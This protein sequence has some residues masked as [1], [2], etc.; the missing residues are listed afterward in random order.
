MQKNRI[1]SASNS[2][3]SRH[4]R[5][6][7]PSSVSMSDKNSSHFGDSSSAQDDNSSLS[8]ESSSSGSSNK[9]EETERYRIVRS[10]QQCT[11]L[12]ACCTQHTIVT[13]LSSRR[14]E[15]QDGIW[16]VQNDPPG[17]IMLLIGVSPQMFLLF[18]C[19]CVLTSSYYVLLWQIQPCRFSFVALQW[20][21]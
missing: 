5:H 20:S 6:N 16:L 8:R 12:Y 10:V 18:S 3:L 13:F 14:H 4:H 17:T 7:S 11:Q 21:Y 1:L 19:C 2:W 15:P 9:L